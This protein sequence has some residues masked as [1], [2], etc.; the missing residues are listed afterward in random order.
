[1]V[2]NPLQTPL[3][4][5]R[6]WKSREQSS[7]GPFWNILLHLGSMSSLVRSASSVMI[8][9]NSAE[10]FSLFI[11]LFAMIYGNAEH[12]YQQLKLHFFKDL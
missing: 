2:L 11:P 12:N 10:N 5:T 4:V 7:V 3:V 6:L 9:L 8:L 1:M